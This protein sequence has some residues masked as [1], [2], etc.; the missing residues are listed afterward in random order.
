MLKYITIAMLVFLSLVCKSQIEI[1]PNKIIIDS[2]DSLGYI[3]SRHYIKNNSSIADTIW[4]KLKIGPNLPNKWEL[5][6]DDENIQYPPGFYTC[7]KSKPNIIHPNQKAL[8]ALNFLANEQTG[9]VNVWFELYGDKNFQNLVATTSQEGYIRIGNVIS[10]TKQEENIQYN[11][12]PNP[13]NSTL[14]LSNA[15]DI[16]EVNIYNVLGEK[17]KNNFTR[18]QAIDFSTLPEGL[19]YVIGKDKDDKTIF[20]ERVMHIN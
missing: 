18:G 14:Y 20:K 5:Q 3:S 8:F 7:S 15:N 16:Q 4:W 9:F 2:D 11:V 17:Q 10:E 19:Y 13:C 12:F 6:F 1:I